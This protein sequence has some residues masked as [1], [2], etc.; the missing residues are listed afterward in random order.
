MT[1]AGSVTMAGNLSVTVDS[2]TETG[3]LGERDGTDAVWTSV[4]LTDCGGT[5]G[6]DSGSSCAIDEDLTDELEDEEAC[7]CDGDAEEF[8]KPSLTA[9]DDDTGS[10][11]SG[12]SPMGKQTR[13]SM[14][15]TSSNTYSRSS[16]LKNVSPS[17]RL[18]RTVTWLIAVTKLRSRCVRF[19]RSIVLLRL[20]TYEQHQHISLR[21]VK[22]N[23][24]LLE[25]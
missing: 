3:G 6:R 16:W 4:E 14:R 24:Q 20:V 17:Q 18:S 8:P 1:A 9:S 7:D 2:V 10:N 11:S 13:S 22:M 5:G 15:A 12:N 25:I 19:W 21:W 23:T